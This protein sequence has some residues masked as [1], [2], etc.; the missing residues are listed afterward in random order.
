MGGYDLFKTVWDEKSNS[1][2]DPL[3][4]G[5]PLN[6]TD[7]EKTISFSASGRYAYVSALRKEGFG[8][9][10]IYKVTFNDIAPVYTVIKGSIVNKDSSNVF[11]I[12]PVV[13][14]SM[15]IK[16]SIKVVNQQKNK[17]NTKKTVKPDVVKIEPANIEK[18][19]VI[20]ISVINKISQK[21][22]GVYTPNNKTGKFTVV[23][24]PGE[25]S[26]ICES[27]KHKKYTEDIIV[28]EEGSVIN[29]I[30]KTIIL[31]SNSEIN[32]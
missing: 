30:S 13:I 22:I 21:L 11:E 16:D 9:M 12:K 23:L 19:P 7:D 4:L 32:K 15:A 3:N 26:L 28:K 14:D 1:W 6:T 2:S 25:Y 31:S 17:S 8:D 20:K 18:K 5:Y 10:D 27:D 29:E 24:L